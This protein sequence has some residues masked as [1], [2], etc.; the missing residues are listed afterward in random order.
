MLNRAQSRDGA[1]INYL[2]VGTGPSAIIVPGVLST[3][4][5]YLGFARALSHFTAHVIDRRGRGGSSPQPPDY[6]VKKEC[7]DVLAVQAATGASCLIGHSFGGL[8]A[9]EVLC[10]S[11]VFSTAALYEPSVSVDGSID[12]RW[13][14]RYERD[15]AAGRRLDAFV[16]FAAAAGPVVARRI[17]RWLLKVMLPTFLTRH[18]R[19]QALVLLPENL[20][21]HQQVVAHDNSYARY[22][23]VTAAVLLMHGSRNT[24]PWVQSAVSALDSVLPR[25]EHASFPTLNHFGINRGGPALVADAISAFV[26]RSSRGT[27]VTRRLK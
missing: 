2:S 7:E 1:T 22:A 17:P 9:L 14:P 11:A 6:S 10:T 15:L 16:E 27:A 8:I 24:L 26:D 21:E 19:E 3:A 5:D 18:E 13:K 12:L 23:S 20:R 25:V 4:G